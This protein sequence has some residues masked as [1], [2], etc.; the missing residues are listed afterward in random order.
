MMEVQLFLTTLMMKLRQKG[1]VTCLRL[2]FMNVRPRV[3]VQ[4]AVWL[5]SASNHCHAALTAVTTSGVFQFQIFS[6]IVFVNQ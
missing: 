3:Q 5:W 2:Q 1:E 6:P 4:A